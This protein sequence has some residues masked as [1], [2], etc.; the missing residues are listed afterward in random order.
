MKLHYISFDQQNPKFS[1]AMRERNPTTPLRFEKL[2]HKRLIE[3]N[4]FCNSPSKNPKLWNL[5]GVQKKTADCS[6]TEKVKIATKV[7]V[8]KRCMVTHDTAKTLERLDDQWSCSKEIASTFFHLHK[9]FEH[10][11]ANFNTVKYNKRIVNWED[12][13]PNQVYV[14]GEKKHNQHPLIS[15]K[16][17]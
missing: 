8:K 3:E 16:E 15:H 13:H 1:F 12:K 6:A 5:H 10:K 2:A 4:S 7:F 11:G 14:N 9:Q 17:R